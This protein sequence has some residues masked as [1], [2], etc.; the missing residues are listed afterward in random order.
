MLKTNSV[1][2]ALREVRR[3]AAEMQRYE[4]IYFVYHGY[5]E[6]FLVS[7]HSEKIEEQMLTTFLEHATDHDAGDEAAEYQVYRYES[8]GDLASN[9]PD[10]FRLRGYKHSL[11]TTEPPLVRK[12]VQ[13]EPYIWSTFEING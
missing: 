3:L 13:V 12:R 10:Y 11:L 6:T 7:K 4:K 9:S 5:Y 8:R 1:F 2:E